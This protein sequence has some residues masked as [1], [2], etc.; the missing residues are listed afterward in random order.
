MR[1][2]KKKHLFEKIESGY[3][4]YAV[5]ELASWVNGII[6]QPFYIEDSIAFIPDVACYENGILTKIYEVVHSHSINGKKL[7]LINDW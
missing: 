2:Q 3:H 4:K 6:E 7:G 1:Q 5:Q